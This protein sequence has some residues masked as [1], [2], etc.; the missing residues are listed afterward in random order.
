MSF[1]YVVTAQKPTAVHHALTGN[2]TAP[3]CQNLILG[4][5][6]RIEIHV[7]TPEGLKPFLDVGVYGRIAIMELYRPKGY[8]Q[9]VLFVSTERYRFCVLAYEPST[10]EIVTKAAGDLQDRI[11]RPIDNGHIGVIDPDCRMF[12][13]HLYDGLFKV[14]PINVNGLLTEAFNI[15]L[16]EL[17]VLDIKFLYGCAKPTIALL[18]QDTK[19][20]R[21]VRT[22]EVNLGE[23]EFS[24]GPWSQS[25]VETAAG[26]LIPVPMPHGG[27]LIVGEQ[28][29]TYHRGGKNFKSIS[30][31]A[32]EM[33]CFGRIDDNGS[34][35][36]LGDH[37]GK[38]YVVMLESKSKSGSGSALSGGNSVDLKLEELGETSIPSCLAYLDNGVVF[39]GSMFGDSQLIRLNGEKDKSGSYLEYIDT[40]TNLGPIVDFCVVDFEN[41]GQGQIVTCSGAFKDG[42]LRIIRNGIGINELASIE[43]GGIKGVW[44]L[45]ENQNSVYDTMLVIS[46]V[47]DTKILAMVDGELQEAIIEGFAADEQTLYCGNVV[48]NQLVQVTAS[49]IRLIDSQSKTFVSDWKPEGGMRI[50]VTSCNES[51]ILVAAGGNKLHYFEIEA[52]TLKEVSKVEMPYEIA[53][54][55]ISAFSTSCS[56]GDSEKSDVCAVGLWSDISVR[57]LEL[58]GLKQVQE[59]IIGGEIIPR[60]VLFANFEGIDYLLVSLGDGSLF[61]FVFDKKTNTLSEKKNMSLGTQAIVLRNFNSNSG[62]HVFACCDRPT[63][64]YSSN[65]KLLYSNVNMKEVGHMCSFNPE[66]E[67]NSL[68]VASEDCLTIGS[69]DEIQKLHIRTVPLG[70]L[71]R[72]IAHQPETKTFG[73]ITLREFTDERGDTVEVCYFRLLDEQ[74][75]EILDSLEMKC[76]EMVL[77]VC[78]LKFHTDSSPYYVVGTAFVQPM[79]DE[80]SEGR[81]VVLQVEQGRITVVGDK[82]ILGGA[83][84]LNDFNG[85]LLAGINSKVQLFD[86]I[87]QADDDMKQM[88]QMGLVSECGHHGH[89]LAL[90]V[91]SRGDFIVVGD[92]MKS[93]SLLNYEQVGGCIDEIARDYKPNW[94]TSIEIMDDD[95][96]IGAE[97]SFN[98]F[99]ARKNT[100]TTNEEDRSRLEIVGE[101]HLGEFVNCFQ[102]GSLVMRLPD[103]SED[104]VVPKLL[105]GT[106]N[107]VI[108]VMA[109]LSQKKFSFLSQVQ[110]KLSSVVKGV[111]GF[112]HS[113]WRSFINDSRES[114][115]RAYIDGDLVES[116]LDLKREKME[117]VCEGL[118]SLENEERN[119]TVEELVKIVEDLTRIH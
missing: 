23:K 38:L 56:S 88:K 9:D 99:T 83:Y 71:P 15:R 41:Q 84:T 78:S 59:E 16:E 109:S 53:C 111:G 4:K 66:A 60:S 65:Q 102:H 98:L 51:Q 115:S 119:I 89:I 24:E 76:N 105:F 75:F 30:I 91:K 13:L 33:K 118:K 3:D 25:N 63:V 36:L 14:I 68:A 82:A 26:M 97:N 117:E 32:T 22:Y 67:P 57:L 2:F 110:E 7:C 45:K 19:D 39:V 11:G 81:L 116:F 70:E 28:T 77:S 44:S 49:S 55:N 80:P 95:T 108:G 113:A 17:Q 58:P 12:G 62:T 86:W 47:M 5:C 50:S 104:P 79:E 1:N 73:I 94:M 101:Y 92:L 6:T 43:M 74:T 114:E 52:G 10:G 31:K 112:K 21:H 46:F 27:V 90:F 100:E 72:R 37:N 35:F 40:F 34:R 20:C 54:V 107:G 64:I 48:H 106:V 87:S 8:A 93:I 103:E 29:I 85:K 96:Y 18:Y 42:S 61:S 69:I